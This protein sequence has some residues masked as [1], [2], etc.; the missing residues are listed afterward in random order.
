MLFDHCAQCQRCCNIDPGYPSLEVTLTAKERKVHG[1]ICIETRCELLGD[2]G[3]TLGSAKPL[4]CEIYPLSYDPRSRTF[5]YDQDCPLMPEYQLQLAQPG[6]DAR[7]HLSRMTEAVQLHEKI[8]PK[9]LR[10]N[11]AVDQDYFDLQPLVT[12][13]APKEGAL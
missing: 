11:F 12:V 10:S 1:S 6:S 4:S 7:A 8:D 2:K 3:C 13:S 5:H 9:F